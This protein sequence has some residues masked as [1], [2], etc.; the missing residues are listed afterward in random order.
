MITLALVDD[1][2]TV[3]RAL[4][5]RLALEPDVEVV[6]EAGDGAAGLE[7]IERLQPHVV[8]MDVAMPR[9]DGIAATARV[10]AVAPR[11][12]VV[13]LTLHDDSD[14]R[15]RA[16]LAGAVALIGKHQCMDDLLAVIRAAGGGADR[17]A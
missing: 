2:P 6:G 3:R 4:R 16:K 7:L 17:D 11:T 5:M 14:T 10:K 8:L 12:H 9:L 15:V 1:E 13:V